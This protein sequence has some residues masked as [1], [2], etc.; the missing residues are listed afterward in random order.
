MNKRYL[1]HNLISLTSNNA[2]KIY[3][4][5]VKKIK[6]YFTNAIYKYKFG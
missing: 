1:H 5:F 4:T 2:K 3:L 6:I